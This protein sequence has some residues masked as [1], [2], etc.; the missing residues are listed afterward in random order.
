M[1]GIIGMALARQEGGSPTFTVQLN[2]TYKAP[3]RTPSTVMV[4]SWV[5]KI[6]SGGRKA[7]AKGVIES[8]GG[9]VH[10]LAEGMWLR[11]KAKI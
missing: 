9:V 3:V 2:V 7:W 8:E 1:G 5:T 4:R 6:E 10:A 11:A